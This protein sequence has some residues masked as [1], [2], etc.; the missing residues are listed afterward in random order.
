MKMAG[1]PVPPCT[2]L[3][4]GDQAGRYTHTAKPRNTS[5][6][7]GSGPGHSRRASR[8]VWAWLGGQGERKFSQY[9]DGVGPRCPWYFDPTPRDP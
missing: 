1:S 4:A 7:T 2:V 5:R 8:H 9:R 3:V 6:T